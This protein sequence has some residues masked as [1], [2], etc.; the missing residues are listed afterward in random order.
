MRKLSRAVAAETRAELK[1]LVAEGLTKDEVLRFYIDK[2]GSQEPLAAPLDEGFNRLA[3]FFPYLL[4]T[5]GAVALGAALV[6]W[7]RAGR[8]PQS[9]TG[10]ADVDTQ[11]EARLDDEL[12]NLD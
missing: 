12:R 7:T 3:W 10:P 4:A 5:S 11:L 1:N 6:R 2:H 8:H 9:A